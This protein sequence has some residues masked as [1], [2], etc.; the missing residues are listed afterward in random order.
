MVRYVDTY[1]LLIEI[2]MKVTCECHSK[3][4]ALADNSSNV[5]SMQCLRAVFYSRIH[6]VC[7]HW[8]LF[9][10]GFDAWISMR[11]NR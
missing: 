8:G 1:F 6:A 5:I 2:T 7:K 10:Y 11:K 4:N 3:V 9:A